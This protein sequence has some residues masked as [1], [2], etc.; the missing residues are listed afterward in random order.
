MDTQDET[1]PFGEA[2]DPVLAEALWGA[3]EGRAPEAFVARLQGAVLGRGE[4]SLDVLAR[5]APW[6]MAAAAA[7]AVALWSALPAGRPGSDT[8][9]VVVSA[10]VHMEASPG[11]SEGEV[12]VISLLEDR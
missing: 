8:S 9:P 10:P 2:R 3:L 7:A 11:Q 12:L 1:L 4:D 6:G 5:W